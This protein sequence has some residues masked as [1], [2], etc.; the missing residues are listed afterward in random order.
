[1]ICNKSAISTPN[2]ERGLMGWRILAGE[3]R[4]IW[5][6]GE[7][8]WRGA[9][10]LRGGRATTARWAARWRGGCELR[11]VRRQL[12]GAAVAQRRRRDIV[13]MARRA[14]MGRTNAAEQAAAAAVAA[15]GGG[16]W[17]WQRAASSRS[18]HHLFSCFLL[19]P[20]DQVGGERGRRAGWERS[21]SRRVAVVGA[22]LRRPCSA[23]PALPSLPLDA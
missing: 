23:L 19:I 4:V 3:A 5:V 9:T 10:R 20:R 8:G 13:P 1:M 14:L 11:R 16:G 6:I 15:A 7:G 12:C 2:L 21:A 22:H 17:W 18:S